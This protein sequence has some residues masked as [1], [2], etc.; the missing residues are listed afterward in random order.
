MPVH[1]RIDRDARLVVYVVKGYATRTE[2]REFFDAV[3]AHPDFERGFNFLG[4]RRAAYKGQSSG[5][6]LAVSDEVKA[7]HPWLLS[8]GR[9]RRR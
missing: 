2:A 4:D 8:V 7:R 3:L 9:D 5:Y 1:F 6:I